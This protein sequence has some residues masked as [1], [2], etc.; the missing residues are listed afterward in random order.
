M[1]FMGFKKFQ[2]PFLKKTHQFSL[3]CFAG[4]GR[5]FVKG[6]VTDTVGSFDGHKVQI[7]S[8]ARGLYDFD[9]RAVGHYKFGGQVALEFVGVEVGQFGGDCGVVGFEFLVQI[10]CVTVW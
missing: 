2:V 6:I 3:H 4:R 5:Y 1:F 9:Q 7:A 10:G 8:G